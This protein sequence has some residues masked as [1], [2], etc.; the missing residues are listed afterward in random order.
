MWPPLELIHLVYQLHIELNKFLIVACGMACH[1]CCRVRVRPA[2]VVGGLAMFF[3]LSSKT[4]NKFTIRLRSGDWPPQFCHFAKMRYRLQLCVVKH[5]H[6]ERFHL[7]DLLSWRA[8]HVGPEFHFCNGLPWGF[9]WWPRDQS[10]SVQKWHLI[11]WQAPPLNRTVSLVH[12]HQPSIHLV[13]TTPSP[14]HQL[15]AVKTV[16]LG[17]L[18]LQHSCVR[19]HFKRDLWLPIFERSLLWI[20]WALVHDIMVTNPLILNKP[21]LI[22]FNENKHIELTC[23]TPYFSVR[24]FYCTVY[25][26]R[27]VVANYFLYMYL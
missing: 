20:G 24:Y 13:V 6:V 4:A 7:L 14:F 16:C 8:A 18:R 15:S 17:A 23:F 22:N 19:Q 9:H 27:C 2:S 26:H 12:K 3:I 11:P 25:L 21:P 10:S 1:S 5:Y